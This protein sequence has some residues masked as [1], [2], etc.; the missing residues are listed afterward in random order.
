MV[1]VIEA[2]F[3]HFDLERSK[4]CIV[5]VHYNFCVKTIYFFGTIYS[6]CIKI[7]WE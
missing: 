5:I 2:L 1:S 6:F 7:K 4:I 3:L